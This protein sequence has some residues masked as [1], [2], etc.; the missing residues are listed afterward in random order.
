MALKPGTRLGP[1]EIL[2]AIGAG[3]MGEVYRARDTRLNREIAIKVL[4]E[5]VEADAE[6]LTRFRR[7]AEALAALNHPG[8]A[9]IF[10]LETNGRTLAIAMELVPGP[11]LAEMLGGG[12]IGLAGSLAIGHQ[13]AEALAAA[14]ERGII[15]RDLK[16]ANIKVS[17]S[18]VV[19]V[20]DFG[21]AKALAPD[22]PAPNAHDVATLT[23][24]ALAAGHGAAGTRIGVILGTAAYMSPEQAKGGALDKRTDVWALGVVLYEM[25][26]GRRPFGGGNVTEV[27]AAVIRDTPDLS[28]LPVG[29]PQPMRRLLR[30][31]LEKD[32][33]KRLDSMR[34][35]ALEIQDAM[36]G[37]G[38]EPS[39]DAPAE[40]RRPR[41]RWPYLVAGAGVMLA[42]IGVAALMRRPPAADSGAVSRFDIHLPPGTSLGGLSLVP[43]GRS[44]VYSTLPLSPGGV[45]MYRRDLDRLDA[46]PIRGSDGA[47][48]PW[49]S[50]DG[51]WIAFRL[52]R[53]Q[54]SKIPLAGGPVVR[55]GAT[56]TQIRGLAWEPSGHLLVGQHE[57]GLLRVP[58]AGGTLET[59]TTADD[60]RPH[61]YPR[62]LPGDRGVLFTIYGSQTQDEVAVLPAGAT[63]WRVLTAGSQ[64]QYLP[65][66]HLVFW[67]EESL[68]AAPFDL[69]RL[70]LTAEP[71]PVVD[72]V[73]SPDRAV[74]ACSDD[75]TLFYGVAGGQPVRSAVWVDRSGR[76]TAVPVPPAMIGDLWLSPDGRKLLARQ[77]SRLWLWDLSS[78]AGETLTNERVNEWTGLWSPDGNHVVFMSRRTG[79]FELYRTNV[80]G[81]RSIEALGV[82]GVPIG[83]SH[84]GKDL[85]TRSA[86]GLSKWSLADKTGGELVR[87]E[88]SVDDSDVSVSP[89]GRFIAF[90]LVTE[91]PLIA[92]RP[93]PDPH[94]HRWPIPVADAGTSPRWSADGRELFYR[95]GGGV[96]SIPVAARGDSPFGVAREVFKGSYARP[97]AVAP[98][99][100]FLMLK[101]PAAPFPGDRIV[102][103]RNWF[104]E[105]KERVPIR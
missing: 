30:R 15:H 53:T 6:H 84:D 93:L 23:A 104:T 96:M 92:V 79:P 103:V 44:L 60:G 17:E 100:R 58:S 36:T 71:V 88:G 83:W 42:A 2:D 91:S 74:F 81:T 48:K 9:Q 32:R 69:D 28:A 18:G 73:M 49:V 10:G 72:G 77:A 1:Y 31:C 90:E 82:R 21:L 75:G 26:T 98:D 34:A 35:I 13:I 86:T 66:G 50:P 38:D 40:P 95:A 87:E 63:A 64:P 33:H 4:P 76:E 20:L 45:R 27:L 57:G 68:W 67:R 5:V 89:D 16:P 85:F 55:L 61:R 102:V 99:G 7:E 65:T 25:L 70:A 14:H 105:L 94:A 41:L 46:E 56:R 43:G 37:P 47:D 24:P 12:S 11:T 101:Q 97:W 19:K 52:N 80:S 59:V 51:A 54:I 78:G 3:G 8:I 22:S 29:T 39:G 62:V